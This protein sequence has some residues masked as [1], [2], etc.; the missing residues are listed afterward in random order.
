MTTRNRPTSGERANQW[1]RV[2]AHVRRIPR[3]RVMTYGQISDLLGGR[4]SALA[5]GW[6]LNVCPHGVP[7]QRVVN[8]AG[9]C[10]T[11]DKGEPGRQ[12]TRLE[13]EGIVF[14][15]DA[16]LDLDRYR[17]GPSGK[18]TRKRRAR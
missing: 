8:A 15:D 5:V 14:R 10:S 2:Y 12:R 6:A 17:F 4:I 7:W 3:G 16:T 11:D 1:D 13:R 9:A 18:R